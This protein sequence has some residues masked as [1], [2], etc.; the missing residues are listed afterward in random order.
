M[1][2]TRFRLCALAALAFGA[3]SLIT[4]RFMKTENVAAQSPR[5]FELRVY[6]CLPGRL[7]ALQARFRDHTMSI[8]AKHHMT[9]IAYWTPQDDPQKDNTLIYVIAHDSRESAKKNWA[10][11]G[12]DPEW[13]QGL[14][15]G[16]QDR[17]KDRLH[18]HGPNRLLADE[19][20]ALQSTHRNL[21]YSLRSV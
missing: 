17:R 18:V 1:T 11:F 14:R 13:R 5:V 9:S 8:F 7:P 4:A 20:S 15:G 16:R 19:V 21:I 2:L 12:K 6:H 3:G 10:E